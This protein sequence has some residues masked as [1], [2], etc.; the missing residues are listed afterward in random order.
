MSYTVTLDNDGIVHLT[1]IGKFG[2]EDAEA[3]LAEATKLLS[4]HPPRQAM[5]ILVDTRQTDGK[6]DPTARKTIT[7]LNRRNKEGKVAIVGLSPY[8]RVVAGLA[9]KVMGQDKVS[10]FGTEEEALKW[11]KS[12]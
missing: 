7:E 9:G 1:I 4:A 3:Y 5:F 6:M 11:L 12:R 10:F 8:A 2:K